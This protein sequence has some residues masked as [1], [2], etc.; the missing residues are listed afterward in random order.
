MDLDL[1]GAQIME[2]FEEELAEITVKNLRA[3]FSKIPTQLPGEFAQALAGVGS[4]S[5]HANDQGFHLEVVSMAS[6]VPAVFPL[7]QLLPKAEQG[8]D[9]GEDDDD[10]DDWD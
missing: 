6:G 4:V 9:D 8:N 10:D 2:L 7:F 1:E 5:A 3:L